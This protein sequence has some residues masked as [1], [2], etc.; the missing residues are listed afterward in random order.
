[1]TDQSDTK[2]DRAQLDSP[3]HWAIFCGIGLLVLVLIFSTS[4]A[5]PEAYEAASDDIVTNCSPESGAGCGTFGLL[6]MAP[7]VLFVSFV[8]ALIASK[9]QGWKNGE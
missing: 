8:L 2:A 6:M 4:G 3:G 1:M 9:I 5:S 7:G